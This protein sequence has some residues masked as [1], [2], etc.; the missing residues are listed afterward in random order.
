A[1]E[2]IGLRVSRIGRELEAVVDRRPALARADAAPVSPA[3]AA[4][5][6]GLVRVAHAAAQ[7]AQRAFVVEFPGEIDACRET[8]R[9][10][11]LAVLLDRLVE[12]AVD[13]RRITIGCDGVA[14]NA[15]A[16]IHVELV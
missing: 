1:L 6:G 4:V 12:I 8:V 16:Q 5:D 9:V 11:L 14:R 13:V 10:V 3:R 2:W 15:A 7:V